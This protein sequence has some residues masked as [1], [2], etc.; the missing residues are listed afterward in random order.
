MQLH[1]FDSIDKF[2]DKTQA[3]L[4]QNDA[5]NN[6]LLGVVQTLRSNADRY[7]DPPY[8]AVVEMN[9]EIVA[10]AIRTPPHKLLLSKASNLGT[11]Q[12]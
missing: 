8:L 9:D 2:W 10:T 5:E 1:R 3:Y 12:L 6:V 11:V 7:R 4:L